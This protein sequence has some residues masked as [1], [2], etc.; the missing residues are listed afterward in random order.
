MIRDLHRQRSYLAVPATSERF[1]EK[2]S[3]SDADAVFIDLEDAVVPDAKA[4]GRERAIAALDRID[5]GERLVCVRVNGL[6]TAW[7]CHDVIGIASRARR[8]DRLLLAKC[9]GPEQVHAADVM[10]RA[11]EREL[12]RESPL[13]LEALIESARGVANV[14]A[15]AGAS[16]RM[17]ALV[18]G[19]GDYQVDM[20]AI[21]EKPRWDFVLSRIANAARAWGLA[22]ID[23]P[24]VDIADTARLQSLARAAAAEGFEGKMCIH[25]SQVPVVNAAFTPAEEQVAWARQALD[26]MAAGVK[27]GK[28]AVRGPRG[29]ML[30]LMHEKMARRILARAG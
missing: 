16:D 29:E 26:L 4:E 13:R 12:P 8:V 27:A 23:S 10:I 24:F 9:E 1:L 30:D 21:G 7:G 20:G 17:A 22:P 18:F 15:I 28:G 14:E 5:W 2:A 19:A 25:P 3:K 11:A 6:D